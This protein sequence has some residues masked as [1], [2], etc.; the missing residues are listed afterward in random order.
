[1]YFSQVNYS[2]AYLT[3]RWNSSFAKLKDLNTPVAN[4][5]N[6]MNKYAHVNINININ[7]N[8]PTNYTAHFTFHVLHISRPSHF[9]SSTFH[10]LH[11]SRHGC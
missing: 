1:M 9:T 4:N 5:V 3:T 6:N 8:Q 2:S 7:I 10:V 11:I